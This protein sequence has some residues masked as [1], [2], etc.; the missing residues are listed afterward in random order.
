MDNFDGRWWMEATEEHA[1]IPILAVC[2][3]LVFLNVGPKLITRPLNIKYYVA[4]WNFLLALFSII[5]SFYCVPVIWKKVMDDGFLSSVCSD[6]IRFMIEGKGGLMLTLFIYSKF[7]ELI[8]TVFLVLKKKEV[9]FLHWFHH[10]TVLL[11][12]WHAFK[13]GISCG[14][15]FAGMNYVVHSIMY[16]YY[17]LAIMGYKVVFKVAPLITM[18]QI[19]QMV[20]GMA[21]LMTAGYEQLSGGHCNV[22]PSNWKLGL[23]MYASYFVLFALLFH[24]KYVNKGKNQHKSPC[25]IEGAKSID[26]A[27]FFHTTK[28]AGHQ[29]SQ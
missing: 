14:L 17:C 3:Y 24:D 18:I 22:K 25:S 4:F 5:G 10:V 6:D 1:E 19:L 15:Y 26:A 21:V 28:T 7:F 27:G 16:T 23:A 13:L 20:G 9:I 29:K 12:C 11:Y 8:D 2:A